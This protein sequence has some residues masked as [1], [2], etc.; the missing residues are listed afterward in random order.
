MGAVRGEEA[1]AST[2]LWARHR[3]L[4]PPVGHELRGPYRDA[5]VRFHSLPGSKRYA[6][7][8]ADAAERDRMRGRHAEWLPA[9]PSGL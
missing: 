1:S 5:W 2:E 3:P 9:H 6:E 4:C 8:E 7:D